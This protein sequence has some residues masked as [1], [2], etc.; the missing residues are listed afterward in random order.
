MKRVIIC[1]LLS[2]IPISM[3]FSQ[4]SKVSLGETLKWIKSKI[5]ESSYSESEDNEL[6]NYFATRFYRYK[7]EILDKGMIRIYESYKFESDKSRD[8]KDKWT[9]K[10]AYTEEVR[11]QIVKATNTFTIP[12][13]WL[14]INSCK[15]SGGYLT[16]KTLGEKIDYTE[17]GTSETIYRI[18]DPD[19]IRRKEIRKK[20]KTNG[21]SL[22][23]DSKK[24]VPRLFKAFI[25]AAKLCGAKDEPF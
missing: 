16:L 6:E 2:I 19:K 12:L 4:E 7:M 11:T 18:P 17:T 22:G 9:G 20:G 24:L 8:I 10:H 3:G 14:E 23:I 1:I 25:H 21:Y 5:D 15:Y 13:K